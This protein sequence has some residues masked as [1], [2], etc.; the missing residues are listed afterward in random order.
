MTSTLKKIPAAVAL[1]V[2]A[3]MSAAPAGAAITFNNVLGGGSGLING[4]GASGNSTANVLATGINPQQTGNACADPF[5]PDLTNA[6]CVGSLSTG[7][8]YVESL[9]SQF[10]ALSGPNFAAG[11]NKSYT[12]VMGIPVYN[13]QPQTGQLS[14]A[15]NTSGAAG[16]FALYANDNALDQPNFAA[17][18]GFNDSGT[19]GSAILTG[20]SVSASVIPP[21]LA[22]PVS[23][24]GSTQNQNKALGNL[25]QSGS[26]TTPASLS[27]IQSIT[28]QGSVEFFFKVDGGSTTYF[29]TLA[30]SIG[31]VLGFYLDQDTINLIAPNKQGNP[32]TLNYSQAG[33][34]DLTT[35][36]TTNSQTV[37]GTD[38]RNN[39]DCGTNTTCY[40]MSGGTE[41]ANL[42]V[43]T[44]PEPSALAL[45]GLGLAGLGMFG[46]RRSKYGH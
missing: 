29:P 46:R 32:P 35:A 6:G 9:V 34:P 17:G 3:G 39:F 38:N 15:L 10:N 45:M 21:A 1:A 22:S 40:F 11:A 24:G 16:N 25:N 28:T 42:D 30:A 5:N 13:W 20:T 23:D 27:T 12:M 7:F 41:H 8:I 37:F 44:I 26:P 18:T 36:F 19:L 14:F 43:A 4:F 31:S 33:G 2:L